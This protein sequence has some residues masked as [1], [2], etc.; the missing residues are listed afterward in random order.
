[1]QKIK[2]NDEIIIIA[3]KDKG[4]IGI[5]TKIV[6][7]KV[8]VEG[9]NLAKKHVKPNPNKGVT[10]GIT[11]IEM[12][13]SISNVA[14]YNPTTKKADRVGI[15]TSKNGIKERFFKSNDKSII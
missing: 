13:L 7:S 8:L 10:G 9:L 4:S 5:V 11:E 3:G 1:M 12:P 15:R 14:I 6:D 2:S